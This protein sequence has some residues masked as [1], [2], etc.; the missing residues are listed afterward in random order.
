VS[1]AVLPLEE[2]EG[3]LDELPVELEDAA[4]SGVLV[5]HQVTVGQ[6]PGQVES[7]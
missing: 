6:A 5:D 4:V 7:S 1:L 2:C 3:S